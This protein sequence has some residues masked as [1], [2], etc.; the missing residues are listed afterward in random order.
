MKN[1]NEF[2]IIH[3]IANSWFD[4]IE[5]NVLS[6]LSCLREINNQ[7]F[8]EFDLPL[9]NK[10]DIRVTIN[11]NTV[12]VEANLREEYLKNKLGNITKFE[13][14]K[15]SVLIPGNIDSKKTTSKFH[16]GR[17]EIKIPKMMTRQ[18]IKID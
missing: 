6:P 8:L 16:K 2:K 1:N 17:L 5:H 15:K 14:F 7:W 3:Q 13:Y 9:V 12:N 10:N 11:G 4:N 18:T